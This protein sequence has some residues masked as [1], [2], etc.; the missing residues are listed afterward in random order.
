MCRQGLTDVHLVR[1]IVGMASDC[2]DEHLMNQEMQYIYLDSEVERQQLIDAMHAVRQ[3][4]AALAR[5]IPEDEWYTPRYHGWSLAAMLGHLN[6]SDNISLL[7]IK[8]A[9]LGFKPTFSK[10]TVD[11][12]NHFTTRLFQKRV[13]STSLVG[14]D[15]N[16]ARLSDFIMTL[17]M[18]RFSLKVYHPMRA[19]HLT[20]EKAL[21][22]FFLFHWQQHLAEMRETENALAGRST[23]DISENE[24][25]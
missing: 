9:L 17:P 13:V 8:A 24:A 4:V 16:M 3:D 21:Q 7:L 18:D 10:Q 6:F 2:W 22:D 25:E 23:T 1:K 11:R 5:S 14:M 12:L 20:I 15:K 19:Q